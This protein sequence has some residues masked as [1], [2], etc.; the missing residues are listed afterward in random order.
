MRLIKTVCISLCI[1]SSYSLIAADHLGV[2]TNSRVSSEQEAQN[3]TPKMS[4]CRTRMIKA[5]KDELWKKFNIFYKQPNTTVQSVQYR[6]GAFNDIVTVTFTNPDISAEPL[7]IRIPLERDLKKSFACKVSQ[8]TKTFVHVPR[9]SEK[10]LRKIVA[11]VGKYNLISIP[12]EHIDTMI[13]MGDADTKTP[14]NLRGLWWMDG[15]PLA[16]KIISFTNEFKDTKNKKGE[17]TGHKFVVPVYDQGVWVWDDTDKGRF[18][19]KLV[20]DVKLTYQAEFN[21][22]YTFGQVT[23]Y[24]KPFV[25]TPHKV[26]PSVLVD[27]T[28]TQKTPNEWSR[29]STLLGTSHTYRL[30][31]IVDEN[32]KHLPAWDEFI[33]SMQQK[34]KGASL[35]P[36]CA[37]NST[38]DD[39]PTDCVD[40]R[41]LKRAQRQ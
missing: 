35:I 39:S 38:G 5:A 22:D 40:S 18:L 20:N 30:R 3:G 26:P 4:A 17:I 16:D 31:Q 14:K 41:D 28:L 25:G 2:P 27:F 12:N 32:G 37:G 13:Q 9:D 24:V 1:V 7:I 6:Y 15:N 33:V 34:G 36:V 11:S 29:D 21:K 23:P 19:Y 10:H 8:E